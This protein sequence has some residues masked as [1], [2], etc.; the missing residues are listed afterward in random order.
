VTGSYT[1][2]VKGSDGIFPRGY[3]SVYLAWQAIAMVAVTIVAVVGG[4][5]L[6]AI[7]T[8]LAIGVA[9]AI[10]MVY[11]F[12]SFAPKAFA[13]DAQGLRLG[14]P[15]TKSGQYRGRN[16]VIPWNQ[17]LQITVSATAAGSTADIMLATSAPVFR[18]SAQPPML[19]RALKLTPLSG[20]LGRPPMLTPLTDPLRY[21]VPLYR[22][23]TAD[24]VSG[25]RS[26]APD[27]VLLRLQG[28]FYR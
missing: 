14:L 12:I 24:L 11:H 8:A 3:V 26:L 21:R 17:V 10:Y 5:P 23:T 25:L 16:I 1:A 4:Y 9:S 18:A 7:A 22:V 15:P 27:S 6:P 20:F 19:E 2:R 13:A 28:D